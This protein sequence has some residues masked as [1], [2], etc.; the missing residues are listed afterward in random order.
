[1]LKWIERLIEA[2][3][4]K[5]DTTPKLTEDPS[6]GN[7]IKAMQMHPHLYI[8]WGTI[9]TT[10]KMCS[11]SMERNQI[12][13]VINQDDS[14]VEVDLVLPLTNYRFKIYNYGYIWV[15]ESNNDYVM[16]NPIDQ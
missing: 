9:N 4:G 3:L 15:N 14:L 12:N 13:I 2:L 6:M 7:M 11:I 1:M 8:E 16:F 5:E 10:G